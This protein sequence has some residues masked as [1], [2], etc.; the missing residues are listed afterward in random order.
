MY[1]RIFQVVNALD[2]LLHQDLLAKLWFLF[3]QLVGS[4]FHIIVVH[5]VSA[6]KMMFLGTKEI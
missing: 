2:Q 5:D 4:C 6:T 1:Q 3:E